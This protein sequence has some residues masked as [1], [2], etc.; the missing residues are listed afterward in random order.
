MT[1]SVIK[2]EQFTEQP[3]LQL[4]HDTAPIGLAFL[5]L[6]CRYLRINQR[7]TELCGISL[8]GHLGRRVRDAF[9]SMTVPDN[10]IPSI[11]KP[12]VLHLG[13][14]RLGFQA[15]QSAP[16]AVAHQIAGYWSGDHRSRRGDED[17]QHCYSHSWRIALL[18]RF[19]QAPASIRRLSHSVITQ[20]PA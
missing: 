16:A 3:V 6:D 5:S 20:V 2:N 19:W 9:G 11:S 1:S 18:E 8:E 7:L 14:K 17:E 15:R 13:K 10:T 12:E 4:I